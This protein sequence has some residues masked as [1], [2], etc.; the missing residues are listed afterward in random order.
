MQDIYIAAAGRSAIGNLQGALAD[1]SAAEICSQVVSGL[2]ERSGIDPASIDEVILG[3][4]LTAGC[5]QN[6]ARQVAITA[7]LNFDT[8]ALTINKVCGSGLTAVHLAARAIAVGDAEV[9]VAGG[10]EKIG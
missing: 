10:M 9:V 7:G 4:V 6:T 8:P 3:H 2:L 5:G 1:L